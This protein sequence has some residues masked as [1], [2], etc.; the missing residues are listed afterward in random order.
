MEWK[1]T[2]FRYRMSAIILLSGIL[3]ACANIGN[4]NGGP[5]DEDPP[6][7][8]SSTPTMNALNFIVKRIE[9]V[10]DELITLDNS[11]QTVIVSSPQKQIPT[12][13]SPATT[14][15]ADITRTLS[16]QAITHI[17]L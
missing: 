1:K 12:E 13:R 15:A 2:W 17:T 3:C 7:F 11:R 14:G 8:V 5:Y 9:I 6:K 10:F 16:V 4:P